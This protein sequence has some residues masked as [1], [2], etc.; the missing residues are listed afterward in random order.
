MPG[1]EKATYLVTGA[2]GCIGAWTVYHLL[3]Q[4]ERVVSFD[5]SGH[6]HRL[7][8]LL[9]PEEQAAVSFVRGD[10]VDPAQVMEACRAHRVT[11]VIHLAALQVPFCK[12]DPIKGAQVNV[13]GTVNVFEAARQTGISHLAY[14]SSIAVYGP[15]EEYPLGLIAH[16][17]P[18]APR[19]L[20]GVYKRADEGIARVYWEDHHLG[21]IALRPYTVYGLGRDQGLT[22]D[23][24]KAM[25]A[26]AAGQPF[27]ISFGGR[28]QLQLAS[29]VAL[30]FIEA[31]QHPLDGAHAFNLGGNVIDMPGLI[32]LI[33]RARPDARLSYID[34][35]LAFPE[36]FDDRA[37]RQ[38][39]QHV[40]HTPL[41]EGVR[42]T[43]S[44]FEERL[45]DG[46]LASAIS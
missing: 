44:Q 8:L 3:K 15:P 9:S 33:R 32:E 45:A 4:G 42:Q 6:G 26:A 28:F 29:D 1:G 40:Y 20:Y 46:R 2:L 13:V 36:G 5:L 27:H 18:L 10:L 23:P 11:H 14:A 16:D 25:L 39:A 41:P 24:T 30:Q 43:V 22:S 21:S 38:H 35:P 17:A 37:L 34:A 7:D 19:T 12:A 31:A